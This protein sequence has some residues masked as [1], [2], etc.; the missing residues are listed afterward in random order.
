MAVDNSPK[1][2]NRG[3]LYVPSSEGTPGRSFAFKPL[4]PVATL[5]FALTVKKQGGEGTVISAPAGISCA[6]A[7]SEQSAK[8]AE[9]ELVTLTATAAEGFSFAGWSG[10]GCSGSGTCKVTMSE[11]KSV[12]AEFKPKEALP[13]HTLTV[14]VTG[15][16]SVSADKG[17][18]SG[19]TSSGGPS[20]EGTYE[21]GSKVLLTET[22]GPHSRFG[23][24]ETLQC[25]ESPAATC[26]VTIGSGDEGVAAGFID[27]FALT[28]K[29]TGTGTGKV[30]STPG[31]IDC[32]AT[33]EAEY[34]AGTEVTLKE[35]ASAGSK[36]TEWSGACTGTGTC[37]VTMSAAKEVTAKF[38]LVPKFKLSVTKSGTGA[39]T[40][41][42]TPA[43]ISCGATCS[44]EY[45]AGKEVELKASP[46]AG[47]EFKEWSG[48]CSGSG[49]CKVT[50]SGARSV[51]AEF[52][53]TAK[54]KFLLK[55]G[56]TGTG[57]GKVTGPGID[58]GSTCEAEYEEGTK[59]TLAQSASAG[60]KFT[61]WAGACSGSGT[62]EVTMSAAK[63]VS[64][65]F[66]LVPKFKLSVTK[67][68]TGA[69]TV[70][71][72][73]AG[74]SCGAT[75]SAE[76]EAGK[77]VELKASP[78]AGSEFK[79][80]SGACSGSGSCKVTM[81]EARSVGAEFKLTAKPKFLLKV[82]TTGT[83][84]GKVESTSP[85]SPKIDC[86]S[87]C[88]AEY[89][90]GTKV[91]LTQ[92]ASAGSKFTEWSGACTGTGTCEVTMSAARSV[93]A[94]FKLLPKP[95]FKLSV[96]RT[97]TGTGT[98]TSS[99]VGI[100]CGATCSF[101]YEEGKVVELKPLASAGSK[102][103]EWSGAC[104]GQGAC[105]VTMSSAKAVTA[106]FDLVPK[107]KLSVSTSG[108]GQ[109]TV[110]STPAGIDCGSTCEAEFEEGKEVELTAAPDEGSE[111]KEWSGACKGTGSCKVT[112]SAAKSVS[113]VFKALPTYKLLV[114]K[115]GTGS[116]RV[117]SAPPI[118]AIDCGS[119]CEAKLPAGTEVELIAS[120]D[121]GSE[122][123]KWSGACSGAGPCKVTMDSA[124]TAHATFKEVPRFKLSVTK[125]GT[126]T[127]TSSPAGVNC[128]TE[129]EH[130]YAA[131]TAV[132]LT[133]TAAHGYRLKGWGGCDGASANTCTL[134]LNAPR[135]ISA[136]FVLAKCK[137]GFHKG[138][139]KGKPRCLRTK[140]HASHRRGARNSLARIA[141]WP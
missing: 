90:E 4:H 122:L 41:T 123:F 31:G 138:K 98:V 131:G 88:E 106:R 25:D 63:E 130:E 62:C 99:P 58:C 120:P 75:C 84:T 113:A 73:P 60:S 16:G 14:F 108:T 126:G 24:W 23:S 9:G 83:G 127:V 5:E 92:A 116:G 104:T 96:T 140:R 37:E 80:W 19:C 82:K 64:A 76:Y 94:E 13:L 29:K 137:K 59:V 46:E 91:T 11:A 79:E 81:S 112:M 115:S 2:P 26:K 129:C 111:F 107:F 17:T 50:M 35:E 65:K 47:S 78:E 139:V 48:A 30:T 39:G 32:G 34:D 68:G 77:E 141:F 117:T 55:V 15:N 114:Q 21:E 93:S 95:K 121:P 70:T 85:V 72:T 128:G 6:T 38:D 51:G 7:C 61:E 33:C 3:Y 101:E 54:P 110:T 119:T 44:A 87:T 45:E 40:V 36:F 10:S 100:N 133:A 134:T 28:V 27:T 109:G 1:S 52:K 89:E 105:K 43:G 66:D 103:T 102:F 12:T 42:S 74:I 8:F 18:I 20:C 57:T 125:A 69:G 86:G 118:S 97:G 124:K 132:T 135:T 136:T 49:T 56:K 67:S 71:S 53:L 22:P